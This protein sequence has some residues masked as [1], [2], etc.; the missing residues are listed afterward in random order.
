MICPR[1]KAEYRTGFT[2]CTD[3][4]VELVYEILSETRSIVEE[5]RKTPAPEEYIEGEGFRPLVEYETSLTCADRCL[6]L[7]EA[8]I[9]YRVNELPRALGRQMEPRPEFQVVVPGSQFEKAKK[10]LGIQIAHGEEKDFP[11]EEEIMAVMELS[12]QDD[13]PVTEVRGDWN[14]KDW[15]PEDATADVWSGDARQHGWTIE[16]SLKE[17]RINFRTEEQRDST[18]KIFV[19][20]EDEPR[21]REIVR[22]IVEGAP[23]E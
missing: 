12:A 15:H 14:S 5:V 13:L 7:K 21:A 16:L 8:G 2:R 19:M 3:C 4:D 23:P 6:T 17:N 22:E 10:I 1:C 18:L 11:E 9:K 20:P